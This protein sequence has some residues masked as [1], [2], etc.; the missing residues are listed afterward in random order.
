MVTKFNKYELVEEK[1]NMKFSNLINCILIY[2]VLI[3]GLEDTRQLKISDVVEYTKN[4]DVKNDDIIVKDALNDIKN[5]VLGDDKILNKEEVVAYLDSVAI[6][7]KND[8]KISKAMYSLSNSGEATASSFAISLDKSDY[9]YNCDMIFLSDNADYNEIIHELTHIIKDRMI[10]DKNLNFEE[11]FNFNKSV[12]QQK[13]DIMFLTGG[14]YKYSIDLKDERYIKYLQKTSELYSRL[15]SFKM[16]LYK[17][18]YLKTPNEDFSP[19]LIRKI[20]NGSL[21]AGMTARDRYLFVNSDFF[22]ILL[23]IDITRFN[24]LDQ[25]V[26]NISKSNDLT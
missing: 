9:G 26:Q 25:F 8:D 23:F 13:K 18:G 10:L 16:F 14:L 20:T 11:L 15:T 21:F 12:K 6:V 5:K 4:F 3:N 17:R 19:Q 7:R 2:F 1:L 24:M 22:D